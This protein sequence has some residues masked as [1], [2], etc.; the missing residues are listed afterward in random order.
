MGADEQGNPIGPQWIGASLVPSGLTPTV[1]PTTSKSGLKEWHA[2]WQWE[3]VRMEHFLLRTLNHPQIRFFLFVIL[4]F[5]THLKET[6]GLDQSFLRFVPY[7]FN[8]SLLFVC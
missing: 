4:M 2:E 1:K 6:T 5:K 3:F 8:V 7:F